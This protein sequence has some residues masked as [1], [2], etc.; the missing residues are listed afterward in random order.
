VS[1]GN[2]SREESIARAQLVRDHLPATGKPRDIAKP[3]VVKLRKGDYAGRD[4][5][6]EHNDS[7][8]TIYVQADDDSVDTRAH[9][10][11]LAQ[12]IGQPFYD[13]IRTRQQLGYFVFASQLYVME[14]PGLMF[15]V[16][17][18]QASPEKMVGRI[19]QFI[20]DFFDT[21]ESLSTEEF[22][23]HRAAVLSQLEE[24]D[25]RLRDRT[26]RYWR[27]IDK[28]EYGF[29]TRQKFINALKASDHSDVVALYRDMLIDPDR[30]RV[31]TW[32]RGKLATESDSTETE[33]EAASS[34]TAVLPAV[35][36]DI[37]AFK[38]E[39]DRFVTQKSSS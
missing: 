21:V 4:L 33:G 28:Q 30:G 8:V 2:L 29:D 3:G 37:D 18:P 13:D 35:I 5:A 27:E 1:H 25:K 7:A 31:V 10:S 15:A 39:R 38:S 11:L 36:D 9:L 20:A 23:R 22:D 26:E 34:G 6:I 12:I 16:Q 14:A 32:S 17:S 24:P 19:N